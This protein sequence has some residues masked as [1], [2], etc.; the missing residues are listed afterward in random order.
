MWEGGGLEVVFWVDQAGEGVE[1]IV[2]SNMEA[3][4]SICKKDSVCPI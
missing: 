3:F 4:L 1:D 2:C